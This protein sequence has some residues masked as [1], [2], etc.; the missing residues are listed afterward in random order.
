S[1]ND[2]VLF[3]KIGFIRLMEFTNIG[4][5]EEKD[6]KIIAENIGGDVETAK[7]LGAQIVQWVPAESAVKIRMLKA[8]GLNLVRMLGV[9]EGVLKQLGVGEVVQ[10]VRLGFGR[11][12]DVRKNLISI[13]YAHD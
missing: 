9:G 12:D 5:I 8:H 3:K 2:A 6:N 7:K 11:I 13:I 10:M 4:F 1:S